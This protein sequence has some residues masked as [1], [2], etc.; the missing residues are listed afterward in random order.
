MNDPFAIINGTLLFA[1][2]LVLAIVFV[3][4]RRAPF[5][6]TRKREPA[7]L[8][9]MALQG[10]GLGL[11]FQVRRGIS[12]SGTAASVLIQCGITLLVAGLV[13]GS[14]WMIGSA[15]RVLGKQWSLTAR[16]LEG[17]ELITEGPYRIVRHPIYSG[18][19]GMLVATGLAWSRWPAIAGGILL[20]LLGTRIR[21]DAEE[22]LLRAMFGD[23]Y[24]E[25]AR[26]V[27]ALIPLPRRR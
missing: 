13:A 18:M 4:R 25:Y 24:D 12:P 15:V 17:H 22:R 3:L 21:T 9:G 19:L 16:V 2:W 7:S 26:R 1:G 27:P 14:I 5:A 10:V 11:V 6:A 20:Y 8:L 23:A